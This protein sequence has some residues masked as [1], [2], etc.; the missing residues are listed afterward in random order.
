MATTLTAQLPRQR[1]TASSRSHTLSGLIG[2]RRQS[3]INAAPHL[4][5]RNYVEVLRKDGDLADVHDEVDTDLELS[6]LT[7]RALE[8]RD[9]APLV[10]NVK[11]ARGGLFRV[12]GAPASLQKKETERFGRLARHV[13]QEPTATSSS[14]AQVRRRQVSA[15]IYCM[16]VLQTPD[17]K[18][19]N[20]SISR[21][22]VHDKTRL[23]G[24]VMPPQ[25][26]GRIFSQWQKKGE[27][28]PWAMALGAPPAAIL[29]SGI[30]VPEGVSEAD[31]VGA[32]SGVPFEVVKSYSRTRVR[33]C[34]IRQR[35]Q[36]A[37]LPVKEVF[38]PYETQ[39][40][41]AAVQIDGKQLGAMKTNPKE[42][43]NRIGD[44]I[45]S[46]KTGIF[47]HHI[48]VVSDDIDI[49]NFKDVI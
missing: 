42:L 2:L 41:W 4:N 23:S 43:C 1:L 49:Y 15:D 31:Y 14:N 3:S 28:I 34:L 40:P 6:A 10:H 36:E 8:T 37:G 38:T 32:M 22:M 48:L 7:R 47:E 46:D 20:W 5:F 35:L 33:W 13:G 16:H 30:A 12:M 27:D 17:K 18:W 25:H 19:T 44:A 39:T 21:A 45:F 9:K 24:L 26:V 29:A 11:G